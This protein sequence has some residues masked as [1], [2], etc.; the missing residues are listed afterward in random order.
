MSDINTNTLFQQLDMRMKDLPAPTA[1]RVQKYV[2]HVSGGKSL[3]EFHNNGA[4]EEQKCEVYRNC[5]LAILKQDWTY[6]EIKAEAKQT[7]PAPAPEPAPTP[8][9]IHAPQP[10]PTQPVPA[11][12]PALT[13]VVQDPLYAAVQALRSAL[14]QAPSVK[15]D[16]ER[17]RQIV[18]EAL[19]ERM[20][21]ERVAVA[22]Y[23]DQLLTQ[24]LQFTVTVK[25]D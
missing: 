10:P 24:K 18:V 22:N 13:P 21:H 20:A 11:P 25:K 6:I 2:A 12:T 19:C 17:I 7:A 15:V 14:P 1:E 4:T 8:A 9:P 23:I 3:E 5:L 16:E